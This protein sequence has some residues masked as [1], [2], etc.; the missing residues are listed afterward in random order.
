MG[1][2]MFIHILSETVERVG[3]PVFLKSVTGNKAATL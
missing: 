3:Q 1:A 2:R